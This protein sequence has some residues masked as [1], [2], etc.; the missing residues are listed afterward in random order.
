[1]ITTVLADCS[2]CQKEVEAKFLD[3]D[4]C[5]ERYLE[6]GGKPEKWDEVFCEH[7]ICTECE[8]DLSS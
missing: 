6:R 3:C 7:L 8:A 1:M 5:Y 4:G 2:D